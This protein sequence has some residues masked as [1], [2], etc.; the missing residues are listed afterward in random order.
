M[1]G[2]IAKVYE[3]QYPS[4]GFVGDRLV[5]VGDGSGGYLTAVEAS[6]YP[7]ADGHGALVFFWHNQ[8]FLGWDTNQESWNV[9]VSAKSDAIEATYPDYAPNDPACCPSLAPVTITYT[10]SGTGLTQSR[11]IPPGAIVGTEVFST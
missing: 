10:W 8:T 6:R 4:E 9:A 11:A 3:R 2:Q 1:A 5:T 7:T